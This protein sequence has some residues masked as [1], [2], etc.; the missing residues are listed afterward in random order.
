[1][2]P[3]HHDRGIRRIDLAVDR[4]IGHRLRQELARCRDRRLDILGGEIDVAVEVELDDDLAYAERAQRGQLGDAG[5][6]PNWRSNGAATEEAMV[7]AL[8]PDSVAVTWMVGKSTWGNGAIGRN[9]KATS[10][11]RASADMISAVAT[12]RRMKGSERF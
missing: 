9:G 7:S 1:M 10:P 6:L 2:R 3:Q 8:A 5:D 12:G 11:N 4:R